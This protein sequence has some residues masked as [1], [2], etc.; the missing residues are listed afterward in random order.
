MIL[1]KDFW[2]DKE[3]R[4]STCGRFF[5]SCITLVFKSET[6]LDKLELF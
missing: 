1:Y 5:R 6:F 3:I 4:I 2:D